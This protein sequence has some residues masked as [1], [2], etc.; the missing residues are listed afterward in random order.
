MEVAPEMMT[1]QRVELGPAAVAAA[2]APAPAFGAFRG[3]Q[4]GASHTNI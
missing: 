3:R 4:V 1:Q 2:A